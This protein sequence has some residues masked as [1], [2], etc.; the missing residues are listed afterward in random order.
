[1]VGVVE[2]RPWWRLCRQQVLFASRRGARRRILVHEV[3]TTPAT[4][5]ALETALR[6]SGTNRRS[7][8]T[9]RKTPVTAHRSLSCRP[10][11]SSSLSTL[12]LGLIG[13][14]L[15]A[16]QADALG[17][18]LRQRL[19]LRVDPP[20]RRIVGRV[21]ALD[22]LREQLP[23]AR[24]R[25]LPNRILIQPHR[26]DAAER[27][28]RRRERHRPAAADAIARHGNGRQ[29]GRRVGGE[30]ARDFGDARRRQLI[31]VEEERRQP[32]P[33]GAEEG[34]DPPRA[35]GAQLIARQ[36]ELREAPAGRSGR[37][38]AAARR[39]TAAGIVVTVVAAAR[40]GGGTPPPAP[41]RAACAA[42]IPERRIPQVDH[43]QH[44]GDGEDARRERLGARRPN[45]IV[46]QVEDA[47]ARGA[48]VE[49][50]RERRRDAPHAARADAQRRQPQRRQ[51]RGGGE[52][53]GEGDHAL[54]FEEVVVD[55]ELGQR[56]HAV[57]A[58]GLPVGAV[59]GSAASTGAALTP[60]AVGQRQ[61]V[62]DE[63][64]RIRSE[65]I[66][67]KGGRGEAPRRPDERRPRGADALG[68]KRIV[69]HV[70]R[71]HGRHAR[72]RR[73]QHG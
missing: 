8:P 23:H 21:L 11:P 7:P 15:P 30:G 34:A 55:A 68:P 58:E 1:M 22:L 17:Q 52:E 42:A 69:R 29:V 40:R 10:S 70:H 25:P 53:G 28:R 56:R 5:P 32:P 59:G 51:R 46:R 64:P 36:V 14:P 72:E 19:N 41:P 3:A 26:R 43:R 50:G 35:V 16:A 57:A 71:R 63:G 60:P 66:V 33:G 48:P 54:V 13:G 20:R 24:E 67:L 45:R 6:P 18:P 2:R 12:C 47:E 44:R 37:V 61:V 65:P 38:G 49:R 39:T 4:R 31:V 62:T 73:H 9:L 27:R